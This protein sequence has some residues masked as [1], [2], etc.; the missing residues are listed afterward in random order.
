[1]TGPQKHTDQTHFQE[2]FG[3]LGYVH[4]PPKPNVDHTN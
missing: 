2:V 1:M 3:R 4:L